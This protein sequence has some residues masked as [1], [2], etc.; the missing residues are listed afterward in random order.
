[1]T[2]LLLGNC[3]VHPHGAQKLEDKVLL[4]I[5]QALKSCYLSVGSITRG[6]HYENMACTIC[7][8]WKTLV[9]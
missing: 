8:A 3:S 7:L 2:Q 4:H 9:L 5:M 1:M 6:C